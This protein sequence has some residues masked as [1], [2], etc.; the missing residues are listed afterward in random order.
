M[1]YIYLACRAL[2]A[3]SLASKEMAGG[4]LSAGKRKRDGEGEISGF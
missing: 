3:L 4:R 2:A 1:I